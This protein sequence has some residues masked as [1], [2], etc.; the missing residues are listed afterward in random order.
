MIKKIE[1]INKKTKDETQ[2]EFV[3]LSKELLKI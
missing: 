3:R 2:V 1:E